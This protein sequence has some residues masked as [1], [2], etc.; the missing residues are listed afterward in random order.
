MAPRGQLGR[1]GLDTTAEGLADPRA[2]HEKVTI[3][4][5]LGAGRQ[6]G[7]GQGQRHFDTRQ[8][9]GESAAAAGV[10]KGSNGHK[11]KA[12]SGY[13]GWMTFR[14]LEFFPWICFQFS[15]KNSN[16]LSKFFPN[17]K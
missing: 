15:L 2:S 1:G 16:F 8:Q 9:G 12:L 3:G 5:F 11:L 13:T 10:P 7:A 14:N 6:L 4:N 17:Y